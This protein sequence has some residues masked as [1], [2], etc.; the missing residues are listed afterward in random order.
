MRINHIISAFMRSIYYI[1]YTIGSIHPVIIVLAFFEFCLT[2]IIYR[3][4]KKKISVPA[5]HIKI[6]LLFCNKNQMT[7]FFVLFTCGTTIFVQSKNAQ[8]ITVK[9]KKLFITQLGVC[10]KNIM[11]GICKYRITMFFIKLLKFIGRHFPV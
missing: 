2:F 3:I 6:I 7:R 11:I 10:N 1:V 9:R 5:N 8:L 4:C